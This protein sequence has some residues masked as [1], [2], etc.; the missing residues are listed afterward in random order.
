MRS[1]L[2]VLGPD[3]RPDILM[4]TAEDAAG[5]YRRELEW[6]EQVLSDVLRR[7]AHWRKGAP[8]HEIEEPGRARVVAREDIQAQASLH[9]TLY[10]GAPA[11]VE[12]PRPDSP[13]RLLT[14]INLE[15]FKS[16]GHPTEVELAP[17]TLIY[18]PNASG[19]SSLIQSL[20]LQKQS[21]E[22]GTLTLSGGYA[23]LGSVSG[24]AHRHDESRP[25]TVGFEFAVPVRWYIPGEAISPGLTRGLKM[26]FAADAAGGPVVQQLLF[27]AGGRAFPY[28]LDPERSAGAWRLPVDAAV[29]LVELASD[30][31]AT[32]RADPGKKR[33]SERRVSDARR[34]LG[35]AHGED[36]VPFASSGLLPDR[37]E[38]DLAPYSEGATID[39]AE[40]AATSLR[41]SFGLLDAARADLE[42]A[43]RELCYL[44]PIRSAPQRTYV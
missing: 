33:L 34:I 7:L 4:L 12:V 29:L 18:G 19:K 28:V 42:R 27:E 22:A 10:A 35:I 24:L 8:P 16:F 32:W 17:I 5:S 36:G 21:L 40:L 9:P 37:I 15:S 31:E 26:T 2:V 43:L 13:G 3:H 38:L 20:L 14:K 41:R 39:A 44:G 23:S 6:H 11:A 1:A 30:P 25:I